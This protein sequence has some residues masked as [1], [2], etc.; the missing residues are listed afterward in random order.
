MDEGLNRFTEIRTRLNDGARDPD[1]LMREAV[2]RGVV[3]MITSLMAEEAKKLPLSD[4]ASRLGLGDY[5]GT[6]GRS[7]AVQF[8]IAK[9]VENVLGI[10]EGSVAEVAAERPVQKGESPSVAV[11]PDTIKISDVFVPPR[12]IGRTAFSGEG[13]PLERKILPRV[14]LTK[15]VLTSLGV[16][17][18]KNKPLEGRVADEMFRE[19]PYLLFVAPELDRMVLVCKERGNATFVIYGV[20]N[21]EK[22]Y[23]MDKDQLRAQGNV[24]SFDWNN[25]SEKW[26]ET[27][28]MYLTKDI[29][30]QMD[31]AY[32]MNAEN[33]KAD[34]EAFAALLGDDKSLIDLSYNSTRTLKIKCASGLELSGDAYIIRAG[35]TLGLAKNA[36]DARN[37]TG[38]I[39]LALKKNAGLDVKEY[40]PL[41]GQ[42]FNDAD[43]VKK[44]LSAYAVELGEGKTLGDLT[45][46]NMFVLSV[47]CQN[48]RELKGQNYLRYAGVAL[49]ISKSYEEAKSY[50]LA[51]LRKLK[52]IAGLGKVVPMDKNYFDNLENVRSDFAAYLRALGKG[53]TLK[54]L[55]VS[56]L[57]E[58]SVMCVNGEKVG[59][60]AY[61]S[62]AA[63]A[64]G[65]A[66]NAVESRREL[67]TVLDIL[68]SL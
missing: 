57:R 68:K 27:L 63:V 41:D 17:L 25:D 52:E 35:E 58:V 9:A 8:G 16:D 53:I 18:T 36:V 59:G 64:L 11:A 62:R 29:P 10:P 28:T 66:I 12:D 56:L 30:K 21:P 50:C 44:D 54:D 14:D 5:V 4:I 65:L 46:G 47:V 26:K 37:V 61:V 20:Q 48:G 67:A 40:V 42:Y 49:G 34:L 39:L 1:D 19:S 15:E 23:A 22:Y 38:K 2:G 24:R 33:V 13:M 3:G 7:G 31:M 51:T 45:T 60:N 43:K 6:I 32:F 55:S